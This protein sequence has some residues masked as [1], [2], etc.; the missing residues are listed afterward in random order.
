MHNNE[1]G[2]FFSLFF[3]KNNLF[4]IHIIEANERKTEVFLLVVSLKFNNGN[5][6][7]VRTI[8]FCMINY[9]KIIFN[10]L[11]YLKNSNKNNTF[12]RG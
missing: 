6:D 9:R 2:I 5:D 12:L 10:E 8:L 7:E 1:I 11:K 4:N 3:I